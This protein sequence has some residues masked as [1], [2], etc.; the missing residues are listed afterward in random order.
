VDSGN[1]TADELRKEQRG[2]KTL[3]G[4]WKLASKGCGNFFVKRC[5]GAL[6]REWR[7]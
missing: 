1:A 3:K 2:D 7:A 4:P 6:N 5:V